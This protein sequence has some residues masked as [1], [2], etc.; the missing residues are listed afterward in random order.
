[1][2]D[3]LVG[4]GVRI[5]IGKTVG[6]AKVVSAVTQANPGVATSTSHGLSDGAVG[7]LDAVAGMV[8]ID[9][10]AI[11]IDNPATNTFELQGVDTT[12]YPAFTAGS[13]YPVTAWS[14]LA[15]ASAYSI[16]GG[17]AD[18]L[19]DTLLLNTIRQERNGMLAAQSVSIPIKSLTSDDEAIGLIRAAAISQDYLVFRITLSD[20]SMRV[21]RGQPSMPGED[22]QQGQIGTGSISVKVKGF[23]LFLPPV[24]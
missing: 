12:D 23:V 8:N 11:R 7:Y 16:G 22:V 2:S 15:R 5:E 17:E 24:A 4:R 21:F 20:G 6:A 9:G 13:F 14:T 19:D 3:T 18:S 10:M 1:M